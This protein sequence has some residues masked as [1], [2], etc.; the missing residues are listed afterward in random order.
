LKS[1]SIKHIVLPI[2][3]CGMIDEDDTLYDAFT[4][5]DKIKRDITNTSDSYPHRAIFVCDKNKNIIGKI[6]QT[7]LLRAL[8]PKYQKMGDAKSLSKA[9]FSPEFLKSIQEKFSLWDYPIRDISS[10]AVKTKAKNIMHTLSESE[11][12]N[13]DAPI[14]ET[15]HHL[16]M[17][18]HQSLVVTK[19]N[20]VVGVVRLTDIIKEVF[21][22]IKSSE[23]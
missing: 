22:I 19:N 6:N 4:T 20:K 10:K 8:E 21:S 23:V 7:D 18:N 15:V 1:K 17:G 14:D 5:M 3:K 16:V 9:G 13:E 12:I 11:Y 2:E